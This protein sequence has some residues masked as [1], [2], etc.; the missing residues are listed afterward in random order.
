MREGHEE[1]LQ[2]RHGVTTC[3]DGRFLIKRDEGAFIA[4]GQ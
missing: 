1:T 3:Y 2:P 4:R